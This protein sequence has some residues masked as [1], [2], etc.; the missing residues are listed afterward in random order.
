MRLAAIN[1]PPFDSYLLNV[2]NRATELASG[3]GNYGWLRQY[4]HR[5]E[6]LDRNRDREG[7]QD[8]VNILRNEMTRRY[9][10]AGRTDPYEQPLR[11]RPKKAKKSAKKAKKSVK[12]G[13]KSVKKDKKSVKKGKSVKKSVRK[14][15]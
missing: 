10:D 5:Y 6:E 14:T 8:M 2:L 1:L 3:D 4:L 9:G 7:L 12:K 15:K 13:K 11:M